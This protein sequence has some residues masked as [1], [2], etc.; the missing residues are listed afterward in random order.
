MKKKK[1]Y[2]QP[3]TLYSDG[4]KSSRGVSELMRLPVQEEEPRP[5]RTRG[6]FTCYGITGK[7]G[8]SGVNSFR[9]F[10]KLLTFKAQTHKT[11]P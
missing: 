6:L 3:S 9:R 2:W 11:L 5:P 1:S 7:N 8:Q 10:T 4:A